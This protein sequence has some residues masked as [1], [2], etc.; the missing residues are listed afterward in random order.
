MKKK[1]ETKVAA[2]DSAPCV[3]FK[4]K[5]VHVARIFPGAKCRICHHLRE[6]EESNSLVLTTI[7]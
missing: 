5:V 4:K 6:G 7:I 3:F 2:I 1:G